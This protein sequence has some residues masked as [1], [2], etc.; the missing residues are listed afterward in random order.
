MGSYGLVWFLAFVLVDGCGGK[1]V[2]SA[3]VETPPP[4]W[5]RL[6]NDANVAL[7]SQNFTEALRLLEQSLTLD[8]D[9]ATVLFKLGELNDA[10]GQRDRARER[11]AEGLRYSESVSA[12]NYLAYLDIEEGDYRAALVHVNKALALEPDNLYAKAL[13]GICSL[14]LGDAASAVETLEAVRAADTDGSHA[15]TTHYDYYL[16][17]AYRELRAFDKAI[18]ALRRA[19]SQSPSDPSPPLRLGE[20]Y[21]TNHEWEA[22]RD[23]YER[24]YGL[25][26][27]DRG[28]REKIAQMTANANAPDDIE[29]DTGEPVPAVKILP[30]DISD[31]IVAS[32]NPDDMPNADAV[33]LLNRS[34][35]EILLDGRSRFSTHQVIK[36][37]NRRAIADYGEVAIPFNSTSQNVGVN[38]AQTI[39]ADGSVVEVPD[40]ALRDV[41]PPESLTFNLYSDTLWKVISFPALEEGVVVEYQVTVED[42]FERG[43]TDNVWFWGS[44]TFQSRFPTLKSQYALRIP[45]GVT[46]KAKSYSCDIQPTLVSDPELV[47]EGTKTYLWE[48]GETSAYVVEPN[49]PP[50]DAFVPRMA[51]SS[52]KTWD[53][54][55]DW[56]RDLLTDRVVADDAITERIGEL[57][58]RAVT[59]EER[60]RALAYFVAQECRYVAI[61]LGQGAFQPHAASEVMRNRYGDCKDKVTLLLTMLR[62]IGVDAYP[63]L[64]QPAPEQDVDRDL[65]SLAQFSHMILAIPN[66]DGSYMWFDPSNTF[67]PFGE[68]S[69]R[70][71]GRTA[72]LITPSGA[73]WTTTPTSAA[74]D[75]LYEWQVALELS[76]DGGVKG[77]ERL[78]ATGTHASDI[79][80]VYQN[81]SER[82]LSDAL[83]KALA[84]TYPGVDVGR[85]T[86]SPMF[87][88]HTPVTIDVTF[89]AESFGSEAGRFRFIPIP[90]AELDSYL[91]LSVADRR[92]QPLDLNVPNRL[93]QRVTV[94]LPKGYRVA[95][96]P[97]PV[98][99]DA[100]F[101]SFR[102]EYRVD[103][104]S[105]EYLLTLEIRARQVGASDYPLVERLF[106]LLATEA[107]AQILLEKTPTV[108]PS[109]VTRDEV[110]ATPHRI[111]PLVEQEPTIS[112][113]EPVLP[114]NP[115][116][117]APPL[118]RVELVIEPVTESPNPSPP[119]E[120]DLKTVR[121]RVEMSRQAW[122]RKDLERFLAFY[123]DGAEIRR[124]RV[125][126]K[127]VPVGFT[128][129]DW[130]VFNKAAFEAHVASLVT[131]YRRIRVLVENLRVAPSESD[132]SGVIAEFTQR[133]D[134]W[135]A[136]T[137]DAEPPTFTDIGH[138]VIRFQRIGDEWRIVFESWVPTSGTSEGII[139]LL[140]RST[141]ASMD[142]GLRPASDWI[143]AT[144]L[145]RLGVWRQAWETRNNSVYLSL[146]A[147][148]ARILRSIYN[149]V[150]QLLWREMTKDSFGRHLTSIQQ[151]YARHEVEIVDPQVFQNAVKPT[152][153]EVRF[154]QRFRGWK[155]ASA[156][157][158]SYSDRGMKTLRYAAAGA[159]WLIVEETWTPLLVDSSFK[160]PTAEGTR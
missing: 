20:I 80:A 67:V 107:K 70:N 84:S 152:I 66:A 86:L 116:V 83:T 118:A 122:E 13:E 56:Y 73:V 111:E 60:I 89:S 155:D 51:F 43:N 25:A 38:V 90:D 22:A 108:S 75:N 54:L 59:A 123:A 30:D 5:E 79:R 17:L 93:H 24:A 42:A 87:E 137:P 2:T 26:P 135:T 88:M 97:R 21:E 98:S 140:L 153:V 134:G 124:Y 159:N 29:E 141:P 68:L 14:Q 49:G 8:P 27:S 15:T 127:G 114:L 160:T 147:P 106:E 4:T 128:G 78:T 12:R 33:V 121:E 92:E 82:A 44:M 7:A 28:L 35:H 100:P 157:E 37:L 126:K 102:R 154:E 131:R 85:Y 158:P 145:K 151:R 11:F 50:L 47:V 101:A 23:A 119:D 6:V 71:Q 81:L 103:A 113:P 132:R 40:D 41:T 48:Y 76:D 104:E 46:F 115:A 146:Y 96:I 156:T 16:G 32:P 143:R 52:V 94:R 136:D 142:D 65:P 62:A 55:H 105:V 150:G 95:D 117:E 36:I 3:A 58:A 9:N 18:D 72:F 1:L 53:A 130:E 110:P 10:L 109:E 120:R 138:E 19:E 99:L 77:R 139:A 57:T 112:T 64:I 63:A 149:D 148:D 144:W 45:D 31:R 74:D 61:Q 39:L 91:S 125:A 133:F 69:S 34:E 129:F